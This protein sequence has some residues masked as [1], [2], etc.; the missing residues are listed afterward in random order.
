V[1][2]S[3]WIAFS[4]IGVSFLL[5]LV[6]SWHGPDIWYHLTWGRELW[7]LGHWIPETPVLLTQPIPANGY[8][9]FQVPMYLAYKVGGIYLISGLMALAWIITAALW[10][11]LSRITYSKFGPWLFLAFVICMQVRFEQR[12]EVLSYLIIT[13]M[14]YSAWRGWLWPLFVLQILWTNMHGYFVFG[15][16]IAGCVIWRARG[17]RIAALLSAALL[18]STLVSPFGYQNWISVWNYA[19]FG[20]ALSDLNHELFMP[21]IWPLHWLTAVFWLAWLATLAAIVRALIQR[22]AIPYAVLAAAGLILSAQMSRNIPLLFLFAPLLW[23][24]TQFEWKSNPLRTMSSALAGVVALFLCVSVVTGRY[25]NWAGSLSRF[26]VK[27]ENASYPVFA[28]EFLK[29]LG[30][31]GKIFC[32]SYDGGFLEFNLDRVQ[33][34]GDSYFADSV[35]TRR[36]FEAIKEPS[37]LTALHKQFLFDAF[38][39]NIENAEVINMLLAQPEWVAAFADPHRILFLK[40]SDYPQFDGDLSKFTYFRGDSLRHWTYEYGVVSWMAVAYQHK[41]PALMRKIIVDITAADYIPPMPLTIAK[42]FASDSGDQELI[43]LLEQR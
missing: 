6:H 13:L 28:S 37:S 42:K 25:H 24:E 5:L 23:R 36:F 16:V 33:V 1:S 15:P 34:A 22:R 20:R 26:G 30:F 17:W 35:Q 4:L 8:W 19:Q 41:R 9:L 32:D 7:E 10:L 31:R 21:Q 43:R 29:Q 2:R 14:T 27:L 3:T 40:R 18:L 11:N 38:L 12:P 39:I